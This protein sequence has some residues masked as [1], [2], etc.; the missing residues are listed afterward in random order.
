MS[1]S[2]DQY[3]MVLSYFGLTFLF[4]IWKWRVWS[5]CPFKLSTSRGLFHVCFKAWLEQTFVPWSVL[6]WS[7]VSTA[8]L[9]HLGC[10]IGAETPHLPG[11][12]VV[13]NTENFANCSWSRHWGKLYVVLILYIFFTNFTDIEV[14]WCSW[15]MV[16]E[17]KH[18]TNSE[19]VESS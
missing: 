13:Q 12:F 1:F 15:F 11:M 14:V 6:K 17:G 19:D 2:C 18:V 8:L 10:F 5:S 3:H 9:A 7:W 16:S 4:D